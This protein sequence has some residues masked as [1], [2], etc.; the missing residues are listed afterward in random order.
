MYVILK[1]RSM[2]LLLMEVFQTRKGA[3]ERADYA[4]LRDYVIHRL[5]VIP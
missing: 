1:R 3:K 2:T 4:G 5:E